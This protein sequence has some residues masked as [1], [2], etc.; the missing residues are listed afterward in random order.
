MDYK[1]L[2][3]LQLFSQLGGVGGFNHHK[4]NELTFLTLFFQ[5]F[6]MMFLSLFDDIVKHTPTFLNNIKHKFLTKF[7]SQVAEKLE[8]STS[9]TLLDTS[10]NLN[11]RHYVNTY[12]LRRVYNTDDDKSKSSSH[13][14]GDTSSDDAN[15]MVD[16]ILAYVA[17]LGNVPSFVLIN[18]GK[19]M[20]NYKDKPIQITKDIF[21]KIEEIQTTEKGA[22]SHVK[23]VL[24]SNTVSASEIIRFVK[25]V[26][27]NYLQEIKNSLGDNIYFFDQKSKDGVPP[28]KKIVG[29]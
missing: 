8:S 5:M 28:P 21:A 2:I 17:K 6:I 22:V 20:A 11:T 9:R 10:I 29:T 7:T 3:K 27:E 25:S 1:E 15:G 19:A 16:A 12:V 26:Y 18:S 24:M 14:Q 23:L 4:N 13:S